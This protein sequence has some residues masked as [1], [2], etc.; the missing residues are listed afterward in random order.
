VLTTSGPHIAAGHQQ[1]GA[2]A[3]HVQIAPSLHN[4]LPPAMAVAEFVEL[5][6]PPD[7]EV[8]QVPPGA[9]AEQF[10]PT[11]RTPI[12]PQILRAARPPLQRM[13]QRGR[14]FG[15]P[16]AVPAPVQHPAPPRKQLPPVPRSRMAGPVP[17]G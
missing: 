8:V 15:P 11:V 2:P 6:H 13:P 4:Q 14:F 5:P 12:V 17:V 10:P 9:E 3:P 7:H 16:L 1:H